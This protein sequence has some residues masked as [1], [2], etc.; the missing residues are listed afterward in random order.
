VEDLGCEAG[1]D[2]CLGIV[3]VPHN[4][5]ATGMS[6]SKQC[7]AVLSDVRMGSD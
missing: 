1:L 3:D 2:C 6:I 5:I 4:L 7:G